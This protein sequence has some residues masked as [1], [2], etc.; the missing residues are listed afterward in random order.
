MEYFNNKIKTEMNIREFLKKIFESV[1][2]EKWLCQYFCVN[3]F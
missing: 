1:L 2:L 3:G